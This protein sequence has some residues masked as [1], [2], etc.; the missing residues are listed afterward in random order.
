MS[1]SPST[2]IG[3]PSTVTVSPSIVTVSP[4]IVTVSPSIAKV[5]A[6]RVGSVEALGR[7]AAL[8]GAEAMATDVALA[9]VHGDR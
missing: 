7:S 5:E 8:A 6:S 4:S 9:I 1:A 2:V 3:S